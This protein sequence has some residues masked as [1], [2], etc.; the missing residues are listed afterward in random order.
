[1]EPTVCV[2]NMGGG[3]GEGG[4]ESG[5]GVTD[6]RSPL[7]LSSHPLRAEKGIYSPPHPL[8]P[9]PTQTH[10]PSTRRHFFAFLFEFVCSDINGR[11]DEQAA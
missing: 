5:D 10:T 1:M 11:R 4:L 2:R 9:P 8:N 7:A 6:D 3:W